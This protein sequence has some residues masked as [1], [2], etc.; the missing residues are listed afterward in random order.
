MT[1]PDTTPVR[2]SPD[3]VSRV[4]AGEAIIV[5]M[6]SGQY[7]G[8][9]AVGTRIWE[10]IAEKGTVGGVHGAMLAEFEVEPDRLREDLERLLQVLSEKGL[11]R[12]DPAGG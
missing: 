6:K 10:L 1:Y 8:L 7:F 2:R 9:D 4:V 5:D 3:A 11:A 12:V